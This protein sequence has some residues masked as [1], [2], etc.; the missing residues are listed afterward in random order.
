VVEVIMSVSQYLGLETVAE[1][2]E[3]PE[4][5]LGPADRLTRVPGQGRPAPGRADNGDP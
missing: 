5:R 3:R 1:Q 4:R 2:I